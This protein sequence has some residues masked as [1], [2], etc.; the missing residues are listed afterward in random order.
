MKGLVRAVRGG[1]A[2]H[3]DI[4][5]A[6]TSSK[7]FQG[8]EAIPAGHV[9]IERDDVGIQFLDQFKAIFTIES[10]ANHFHIGEL[11]KDLANDSSIHRRVLCDQ[12]SH[13]LIGT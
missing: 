4:G 2:D 9:D 13:R 6:A 7:F 3:D 12:H 1:S 5:P 11:F 8:R 10:G